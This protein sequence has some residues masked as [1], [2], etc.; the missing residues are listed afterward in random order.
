VVVVVS[1]VVRDNVVTSEVN[2]VGARH[3]EENALVLGN[4]NI[5]SLL[6]VLCVC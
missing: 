2:G 1:I 4:G 3:L 5:K 6:V